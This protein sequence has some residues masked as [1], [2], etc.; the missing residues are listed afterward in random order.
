MEE[1]FGKLLTGLIPWLLPLAL[2]GSFLVNTKTPKV[3]GKAEDGNEGKKAKAETK[4]KPATQPKQE[5]P[6]MSADVSDSDMAE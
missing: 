5:E 2:L 6:S 4:P 1:L 3:G